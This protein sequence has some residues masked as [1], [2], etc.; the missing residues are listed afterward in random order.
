MNVFKESNIGNL[1]TVNKLVSQPMEGNDAV[2]GGKPSERN[3]DRYN[4][5]A[6][7]N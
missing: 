3:I 7:G 1:T 2:D 4:R 6:H 5:L